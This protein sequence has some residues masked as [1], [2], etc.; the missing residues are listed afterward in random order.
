MCKI[1]INTVLK[2]NSGGALMES[3]G[4]LVESTQTPS[5]L[6]KDSTRLT[7]SP[8]RV[9]QDWWGSVKYSVMMELIG[10][11]MGRGAF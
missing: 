1:A 5:R 4:V 6:Y 3:C 11:F 2:S 8:S 9:H 7:Q 10:I